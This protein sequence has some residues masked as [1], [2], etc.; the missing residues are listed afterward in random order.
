M[1]GNKTN[2]RRLG[3][4]RLPARSDIPLLSLQHFQICNYAEHAIFA[5]KDFVYNKSGGSYSSTIMG[6]RSSRTSESA[7]I[8]KPFILPKAAIPSRRKLL[9]SRAPQSS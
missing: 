3:S 1:A 6:C 5:P 9:C 8:L 4:K 7:L 2:V